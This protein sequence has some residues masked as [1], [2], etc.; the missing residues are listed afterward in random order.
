V[1]HDHHHD[2][3]I[4]PPPPDLKPLFTRVL[5]DVVYLEHLHN[6]TFLDSPSETDPYRIAIERLTDKAGEP[7]DTR[8]L[9]EKA[10]A[11]IGST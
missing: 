7:Q 5:P 8:S 3:P 1:G 9:L 6:A 4:G 10:L 11:S 2:P